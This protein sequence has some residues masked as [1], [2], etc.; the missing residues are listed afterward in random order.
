V[1]ILVI[2]DGSI[3]RTVEIAREAG[4]RIIRLPFHPFSYVKGAVDSWKMA[5]AVNHAFPFPDCD[6]I[7]QLGADTILETPY[8]LERLIEKMEGDHKLVIAGGEIE[9]EP[10][11]RDHVR[12]SGRI[13]DARFWKSFIGKFPEVVGWETVP[14]FKARSLGFK[15]RSFPE[16]KMRTQRP[17]RQIKAKYGMAMKSVGYFPPFALAKCFLSIVMTRKTGISLTISYLFT[18]LE[19]SLED[20][21]VKKWLRLR[22]VKR[23]LNLR[24]IFRTLKLRR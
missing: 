14:L 13:Y 18:S 9:G 10:I 20:G 2:D 12:G 19:R 7:L 16:V 22:Q 1:D 8:Y 24:A 11:N 17:T 15:V 21:D 5:T 4:V 3:D 23:I 6:Y